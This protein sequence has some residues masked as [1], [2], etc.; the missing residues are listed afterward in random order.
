MIKKEL[1]INILFNTVR[2]QIYL[3]YLI[4]FII[5][6]KKIRQTEFLYVK[7]LTVNMYDFIHI[8]D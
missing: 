2:A 5:E 6:W 4:L 8:Y 7:F 1:L 3:F